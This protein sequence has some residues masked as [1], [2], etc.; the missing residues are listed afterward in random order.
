LWEV[1]DEDLPPD[2]GIIVDEEGDIVADRIRPPLEGQFGFER[3]ANL[4]LVWWVPWP[5]DGDRT[6][7]ISQVDPDG[8]VVRT[9]HY[10]GTDFHPIGWIDND[11][12]VARRSYPR[13]GSL[14][15]AVIINLETGLMNAIVGL[16]PTDEDRDSYVRGV[17]TGE[18]AMVDTPDSCLNI[19]PEASLD[20]H[21][22]R[23]VPN[24]V[25]VEV[26]GDAVQDESGIDWL[27]VGVP[28]GIQG[29]ASTEFLL[30]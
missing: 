26:A 22:Q 2:G 7:Y 5:R 3:T 24:G 27:P 8:T 21:A 16:Q 19:R 4:D 28:P 9:V 14:A 25:L 1:E 17:V 20:S 11:R 15:D 18:F 13:E 29:W 23:C 6:G 12:V 30:R 10:R